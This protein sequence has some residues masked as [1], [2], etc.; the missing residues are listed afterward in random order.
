MLN[1][2]ESFRHVDEIRYE[3]VLTAVQELKLVAVT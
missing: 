2:M 3:W 1:T